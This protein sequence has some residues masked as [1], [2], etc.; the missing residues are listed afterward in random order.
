[1]HT[2]VERWQP[3]AR[4]SL[5]NKKRLARTYGALATNRLLLASKHGGKAERPYCAP[6]P[7]SEIYS[8]AI[9]GKCWHQILMREN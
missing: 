5:R 3:S 4:Q 7:E 8:P 2:P 9:P 6:Q 1:M